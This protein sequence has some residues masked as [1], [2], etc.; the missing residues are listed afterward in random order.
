VRRRAGAVDSI[1]IEPGS[2]PE[3]SVRHEQMLTGARPVGYIALT[4]FTQ[5]SPTE[6][7]AA[8]GRL[9]ASDARALIL[10]LRA[11]PGGVLEAAIEIA[12]RFVREGPIATTES[13]AGRREYASEAVPGRHAGLPLIVL[14]DGGSA[15]ASEVLAGA[16]QD[17]R[18]AVIVGEPTFGKAVVQTVTRFREHGVAVKLTTAVFRTPSGRALGPADV[19]EGGA[20]GS[21]G[22]APAR[23]GIEP[24]LRASVAG[25]DRARIHRWLHSYD[26]P[27]AAQGELERWGAELGQALLPEHGADAE[28]ELALELLGGRRPGPRRVAESS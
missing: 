17:H 2:V 12:G 20:N 6:F 23:R 14:V 16:L 24:D 28:L 27:P 10:D 9:L 21:A 8:L 11:N 18:A 22:F 5:R 25:E 4:S 1:R 19:S 26:P 7:D 13:R 3:P 15:S